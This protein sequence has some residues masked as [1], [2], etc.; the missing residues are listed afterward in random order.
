[1]QAARAWGLTPSEFYACSTLDQAIMVQ[2][3]VTERGMAAFETEQERQ[4]AEARLGGMG[5]P[6]GGRGTGR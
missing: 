1:M 2:T 4:A 5:R 3:I 6:G